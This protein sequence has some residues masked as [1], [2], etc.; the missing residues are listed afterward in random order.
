MRGRRTWPVRPHRGRVLAGVALGLSRRY[1]VHVGLLRGAFL[2]LTLAW[3]LGVLLYLAGWLILPRVGGRAPRRF[4]DI[5]KN[6]VRDLRAEVRATGRAHARRVKN[7]R[8]DDQGQRRGLAVWLLL[9]GLITLLTSFGAF[10]WVTPARAIGL[11]LLSLGAAL[12]VS[13]PG[14]FDP[15]SRSTS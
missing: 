5:P 13:A 10:E 11:A 4:A 3:G 2:L 15:S 14:L 1:D 12:L 8:H 9:A 6:N 7:L